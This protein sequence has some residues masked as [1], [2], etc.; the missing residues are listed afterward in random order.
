MKI[1]EKGLTGKATEMKQDRINTTARKFNTFREM[2]KSSASKDKG[3]KGKGGPVREVYL[4]FMGMKIRVHEEDGVGTIKDEDV[5]HVKAAT[6]KFVGCNGDA[7]YADIKVCVWS[8]F[9][10]TLMKS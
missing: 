5:P 2:S 9:C 1:K 8:S 7:I 6:M 4:E 10:K 3:E